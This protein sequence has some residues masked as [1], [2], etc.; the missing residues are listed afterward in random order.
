MRIIVGA[1]ASTWIYNRIGAFDNRMAFALG[2]ERLGHEVYFMGDIES[3]D[4]YDTAVPA[5]GW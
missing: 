5:P 3:K 1:N 4:C 2:F